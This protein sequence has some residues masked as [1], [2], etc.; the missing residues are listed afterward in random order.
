[1]LPFLCSLAM[2]IFAVGCGKLKKF[3]SIQ[4]LLLPTVAEPV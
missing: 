2:S 4:G 1:M 3:F